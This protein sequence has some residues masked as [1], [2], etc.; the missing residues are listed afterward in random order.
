MELRRE[1]VDLC[2]P[3]NFGFNGVLPVIQKELGL[4][5]EDSAQNLFFSNTFD[6]REIGPKLL[7]KVLKELNASTGFYEVQTGQTIPHMYMTS[8][9]EN[10]D[11]IPEVVAKE[12]DIS[13][14]EIDWDDWASNVGVSYGD[15]CSPADF[16]PS[17]FGLFSLFVNF[18]KVKDGSGQTK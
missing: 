10:L 9:P 14:L 15:D 5:D 2:R 16:G 17:K 18:E 7:S 4:K 6:F 13:L 3:V 11:W 8:L 12:M 1:K